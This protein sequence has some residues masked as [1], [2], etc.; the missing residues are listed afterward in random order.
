LSASASPTNVAAGLQQLASGGVL[1]LLAG[2]LV[3]GTLWLAVTDQGASPSPTPESLPT[4]PLPDSTLSPTATGVT[5]PPPTPITPC[6]PTPPPPTPTFVSI[7]FPSCPPPDGWLP[8]WVERGDKLYTLAWRA[9]TSTF[10]LQY[11]NCLESATLQPGRIIYLPPAFFATPTP[12]PCGPP[13]GW[14]SYTVQSGDT[15]YN[16]SARLGISMEEIRQANCMYGYALWTG[17]P[18]YLPS[19]PPTITP[20]A[21]F[22]PTP[23]STF[24]ATWTPSPTTTPTVSPTV[25]YTATPSPTATHTVTPTL[26]ATPTATSTVTA[27]PTLTPTTTPTSTLTPTLTPTAILTATETTTP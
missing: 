10:T 16:L 9:G 6:S 12:I 20:T 5:A 25:T 24:T 18:L 23:T 4:A 8:Y 22:L 17:Q 11:A 3:A 26:T 7:L 15:L 27:T 21:T 1:A 14:I 13:P 19:L 2:T